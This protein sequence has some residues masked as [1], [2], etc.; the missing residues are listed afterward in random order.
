MSANEDSRDALLKIVTTLADRRSLL[1]RAHA[2]GLE[3]SEPG[4]RG[5]SE[6]ELYAPKNGGGDY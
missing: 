2:K 6:R 3:G 1:I 5:R 4:E